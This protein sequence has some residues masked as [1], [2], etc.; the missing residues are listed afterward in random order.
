MT[1]QVEFSHACTGGLSSVSR[2]RVFFGWHYRCR[3]LPNHKACHTNILS[4]GPQK[5]T[6]A[7]KHV[8]DRVQLKESDV[9]SH[10][11]PSPKDYHHFKENLGDDRKGGSASIEYVS[12]DRQIADLLTKGFC[13]LSCCSNTLF[14][15]RTC[16]SCSDFLFPTKT[17][18]KCQSDFKKSA[19]CLLPCCLLP[20]IAPSRQ[21]TSTATVTSALQP[22]TSLQCA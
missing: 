18:D 5:V 9:R 11:I 21:A 13:I 12:T 14:P 1:S 4:F 17:T 10:E 2:K 22:L 6:L 3:F 20:L 15:P 8:N 19:T 7:K 16:G